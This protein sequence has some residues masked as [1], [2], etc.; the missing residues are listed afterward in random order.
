MRIRTTSA[1]AAA[2]AFIL[3]SL[4]SWAIF[5]GQR[6]LYSLEARN[7]AEQTLTTL[8]TSLKNYDD[9]GAAIEQKRRAQGADHRFSG[10][11]VPAA[12]GFIRGATRLKASSPRWRPRGGR[13]ERNAN[14]AKMRCSARCSSS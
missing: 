7:E 6:L 4:A 2:A 8:F 11:S 13:M 3:L 12:S 9:F 5:R 10:F 14:T 1:I